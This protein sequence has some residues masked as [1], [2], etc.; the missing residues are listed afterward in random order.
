MNNIYSTEQCSKSVNFISKTDIRQ[1][2]LDLMARFVEI[3]FV[4]PKSRQDQ[5]V[6]ELSY[7]FST[8]QLYRND[9][10]KLS[11]Y[12][13]PS[14]SNKKNKRPQM[15]NSKGFKNLKRLISMNSLKN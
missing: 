9:I 8:L 5:I 12:K 6:N 7:S 11:T 13:I 2:K 1:C 3:Q 4:N 15:K 14:S 10:K